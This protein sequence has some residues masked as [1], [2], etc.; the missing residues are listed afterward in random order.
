MCTSTALLPVDPRAAL[1]QSW[2]RCWSCRRNR[3]LSSW[4][5]KDGDAV[6]R[7][8]TGTRCAGCS[9]DATG[10]GWSVE[11]VTSLSTGTSSAGL[12]DN[13]HG[14]VQAGC[15]IWM[16]RMKR[17]AGVRRGRLKGRLQKKIE[18]AARSKRDAPLCVSTS[19]AMTGIAE[20]DA[21][22]TAAT[23]S[24]YVGFATIPKQVERRLARRPFDLNIMV[25]GMGG[26]M[27]FRNSASRA[28]IPRLIIAHIPPLLHDVR[29]YHAALSPS[30]PP[31]PG[32]LS[33]A[34]GQG[35][36]GK[37]TFVNTLFAT[38]LSS[39]G[40]SEHAPGTA[41]AS[42]STVDTLPGGLR[43]RTFGMP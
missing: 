10:L 43:A 8:L 21:G 40:D 13:V 11:V 42:P 4:R 30:S 37:R 29:A 12:A 27:G 25:V 19:T 22:P 23:P 1:I 38:N 33:P 32:T 7:D 20:P 2:R 36:T 15:C 39:S 34:T 9:D 31:L 14:S 18:G 28:S 6:G 35:G 17:M 5:C 24:S 16:K 3:S 26:C 41:A